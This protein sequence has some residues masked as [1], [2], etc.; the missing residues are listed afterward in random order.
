MK[1]IG[2]VDRIE[3]RRVHLIV[4]NDTGE[5]IL[6]EQAF[7][8]EPLR[9]GMAFSITIERNCSE[10]RRLVQEIEALRGKIGTKAL[11]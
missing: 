8:E 4:S 7:T 2:S 5:I 11:T 9:Q 10:E 6:P 1:I 3:N